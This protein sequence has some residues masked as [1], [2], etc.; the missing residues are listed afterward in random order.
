M[1]QTRTNLN[2]TNILDKEISP[3]I[4]GEDKIER[5]HEFRCAIRN[6]PLYLFEH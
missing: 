3:A 6:I 1:K 4:T 5:E 2:F